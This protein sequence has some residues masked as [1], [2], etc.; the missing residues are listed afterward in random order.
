MNLKER[1]FVIIYK[2]TNN[3]NGRIYIGQTIRSITQ[4][5]TAHCTK[6]GSRSYIGKAI[7]AHGRDN[8]SIEQIDSASTI[9]ELNNKEV[10]WIAYYN[11]TDLSIGYNLAYGGDNR[12][13][14]D[15]TKQK[16]AK[17]HLGK[18]KPPMSEESKKRIS[19]FFKGRKSTNKPRKKGYKRKP[20]S[21]EAIEKIRQRN[22]GKKHTEET[23]NKIREN[24][25][26]PEVIAKIREANLGRKAS[27][28]TK[29][30]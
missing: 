26:K 17:A 14:L 30:Y 7:K 27:E 11:S 10:Y 5:F 15:S 20:L 22:I 21:Q 8:F 24:H 19:Q 13:M 1:G 2:I 3:I 16:I 6:N 28:E 4:R 12:K 9:E 23:K 18:K 29:V 25:K